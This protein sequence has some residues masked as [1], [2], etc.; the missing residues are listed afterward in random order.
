MVLLKNK[1]FMVILWIS[2]TL[3]LVASFLVISTGYFN[4]KEISLLTSQCYENSGEKRLDN[5]GE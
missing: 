5:C 3:L 1:Y 4:T 2:A